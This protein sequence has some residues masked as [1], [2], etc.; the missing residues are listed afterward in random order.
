MKFYIR[1]SIV[2]LVMIFLHGTFTSLGQELYSARGYWVELHK[3]TY[4]KIVDKRAKGD[5]LTDNELAYLADYEKYLDTYYQRMTEAEKAKYDQMKNLW[6][7]EAIAAQSEKEN[8]FELRPRDR[9]FNGT[10]GL[11]YGAALAGVTSMDGAAA[12][13]VP[14]IMAGLWQLGPIINPKK[15]ENISQATM[16]AGNTGKFLGLGYGAALGLAVGGDSE[17]TG[18]LVLAFSTIGSISLGEVAFQMQK[19]KPVSEGH[20]EMMRHYGFL[21]PGIAILGLGA[22]EPDNANL[23]G[24]TLLA[25]GVGGLLIGNQ[26]AKKYNYTSGDV[27]AISSLTLITTG[28][29]FTAAVESFDSGNSAGLLLI[30]AATAIAGTIFGQKAVKGISLSKRQGSTISLSSGGAALIGLGIVALAESESPAV[31]IG[32]PSALALLTH[33]LI[34]HSYKMKNLESKVNLGGSGRR[35]VS[36]SM[37]ATPENYFVN[38]QLQPEKVIISNNFPRLAN[39]IINLKLTF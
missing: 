27:D 14:L 35:P 31:I 25:G 26:V 32:V 6:D 18:D 24:A 30:P 13:G 3:E 22:T 10:Y 17:N 4:K 23:I 2:L 38:K 33:Q 11:Y 19:R 7:T 28:L 16:R 36:F 5:S 29:G 8:D 9:F 37:K 12:V 15:Y 21:G 20:I 1:P 39:P 34:F